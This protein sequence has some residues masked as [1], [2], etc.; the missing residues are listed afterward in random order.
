MTNL[1]DDVMATILETNRSICK[2]KCVY[3]EPYGNNINNKKNSNEL[4]EY[5]LNV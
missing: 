4:P 2:V 1:S 5:G 3:I